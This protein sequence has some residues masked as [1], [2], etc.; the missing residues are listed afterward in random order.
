MHWDPEEAIGVLEQEP[1]ARNAWAPEGVLD[2]GKKE[3][4]IFWATTI[5]GR[6]PATD[7]DGDNGYNHRIYATRTKDWKTF[8]KSELFFDPGFSVI[9]STMVHDG[10]RWIVIPVPI[11]KAG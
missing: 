6:F 11:A 4:I 10:R 1:G 5:P 9:D 8:T 3:W 7:K 2:T